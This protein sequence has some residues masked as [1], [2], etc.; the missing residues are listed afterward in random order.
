MVSALIYAFSSEL[1]AVSLFSGVRSSPW[2]LTGGVGSLASSG[3]VRVTEQPHVGCSRQI[4][5]N[6]TLVE[7]CCVLREVELC[8]EVVVVV[9]EAGGEHKHQ[10]A[11]QLTEQLEQLAVG[12]RPRMATMPTRKKAY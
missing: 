1:L 7:H 8:Y 12:N 3:H 10:R 4:G 11:A 9:A 5:A 6:R 2:S